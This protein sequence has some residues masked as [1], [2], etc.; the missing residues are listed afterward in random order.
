MKDQLLKG[1]LAVLPEDEDLT[2]KEGEISIYSF[3]LKRVY[4]NC[5]SEVRQALKD[6]VG[7]LEVNEEKTAE[8]LFRT[9]NPNAE[10]S[11]TEERFKELYYREAKALASSGEIIKVKEEK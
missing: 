3:D 9:N 8:L 7:G 4:N 2:P 10:W 6:Y 5:L 11:K 1:L